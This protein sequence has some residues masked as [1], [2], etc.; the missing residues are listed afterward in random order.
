M[1]DLKGHHETQGKRIRV[2][3]NGAYIA[4][5]IATELVWEH[6]WY[7]HLYIPQKDVQT[8]YL[9][10]PD[11]PKEAPEAVNGFAK[12]QVLKLTVGGRSTDSVTQVVEGP[13]KEYIRFQFDAMGM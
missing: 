11:Q 12:S 9:S 6:K 2:L 4:D 7:P 10:E 8:Q 13:L 3:F 5:S 1:A